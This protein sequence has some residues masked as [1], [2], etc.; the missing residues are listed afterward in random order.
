MFH[1]YVLRSES[2]GRYYF[3]STSGLERRLAEHNA[4]LATAT[5][6]RGPWRLV[7]AEEHATRGEA[8]RRE[9]YFKTGEGRREIQAILGNAG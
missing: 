4:D 2:T 9:R 7:D 5:K 3:G 6:H 1:V 8:M